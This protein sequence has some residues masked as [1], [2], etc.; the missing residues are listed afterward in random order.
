MKKT[1]KQYIAAID[2]NVDAYY[3][4]AIDY[5]TFGARQ[6]ELWN[7]IV[8]AGPRIQESVL[9]VLRQRLPAVAGG[10]R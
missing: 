5:D 1:A 7:E 2:Q 9:R 3:A 10:S 6:I 8:A 4:D